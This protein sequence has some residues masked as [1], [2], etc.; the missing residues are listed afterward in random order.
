MAALT[1]NHKRVTAPL[2]AIPAGTTSPV[3]AARHFGRVI[4]KQ[5]SQLRT[6]TLIGGTF[7]R[8]VGQMSQPRQGLDPSDA[9]G[10]RQSVC[11]RDRCLQRSWSRSKPQGDAATQ[12]SYR[13]CRSPQELAPAISS[14]A[15]GSRQHRLGVTEEIGEGF[16]AATPH[17][18]VPLQ[19]DL[20]SIPEPVFTRSSRWTVRTPGP[21]SRLALTYRTHVC[22]VASADLQTLRPLGRR[23]TRS[24]CRG[25]L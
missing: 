11:L 13:G 23:L 18:S 1:A 20:G 2:Q 17:C 7:V 4:H 21:H 24:I 25:R 9:D 3:A 19:W 10:R 6:G 15:Q 8:Q 12:R 14:V 16:T 5:A 22:A